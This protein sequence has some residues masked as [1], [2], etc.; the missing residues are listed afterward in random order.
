M[1]E[2]ELTQ[3]KTESVLCQIQISFVCKPVN[4]W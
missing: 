4:G 3:S 2:Y 1:S